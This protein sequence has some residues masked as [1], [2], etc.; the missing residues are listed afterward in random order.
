MH[1]DTNQLMIAFDFLCLCMMS[2]IITDHFNNNNARDAYNQFIT[3][4]RHTRGSYIIHVQYLS[5]KQIVESQGIFQGRY[6]G[7]WI[8]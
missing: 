4:N 2:I 6:N 7:L 8:L 1:L 5:N 3:E